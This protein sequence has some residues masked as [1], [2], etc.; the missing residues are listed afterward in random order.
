[1]P[2]SHQLMPFPTCPIK[3]PS[4]DQEVFTWAAIDRNGRRKVDGTEHVFNDGWISPSHHLWDLVTADQNRL[5]ESSEKPNDSIAI[6]VATLVTMKAFG[7]F[8]LGDTD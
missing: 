7:L 4:R 3:G 1:M 2:D 6:R 8:P 5:S